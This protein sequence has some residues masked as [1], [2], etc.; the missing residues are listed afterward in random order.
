MTYE[1]ANAVYVY[2]EW[3]ECALAMEC[4]SLSMMMKVWCLIMT[5][6]IGM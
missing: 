3:H 6:S 5:L 2:G 1:R 4:W